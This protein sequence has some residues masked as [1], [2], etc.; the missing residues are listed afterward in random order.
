L[1]RQ[2]GLLPASAR[3]DTGSSNLEDGQVWV[4]KYL[5]CPNKPFFCLSLMRFDVEADN[6]PK[7]I[8]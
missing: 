5:N 8:A 7:A 3:Q 4:L 2:A 1:R 6:N